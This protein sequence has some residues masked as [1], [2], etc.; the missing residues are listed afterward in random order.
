MYELTVKLFCLG[1]EGKLSEMN[2]L[3]KTLSDSEKAEVQAIT[4]TPEFLSDPR[5]NAY[6]PEEVEYLDQYGGFKVGE[7]VVFEYREFK[8][9]ITEMDLQA[10]LE[11]A[12][13]QLDYEYAERTFFNRVPRPAKIE[14]IYC[15]DGRYG[16]TLDPYVST[17]FDKHPLKKKV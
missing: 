11:K 5:V 2:E 1:K 4:R 14:Q 6:R 8:P 12:G 9:G 13:G 16:Y 10:A 7:E 3:L 17:S 15:R